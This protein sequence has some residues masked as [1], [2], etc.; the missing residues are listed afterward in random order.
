[1]TQ[2]PLTAKDIERI[3]ILA[4]DTISLNTRVI[5]KEFDADCEFGDLLVD[6]GPT[7]E[8]LVIEKDKN[9][10]LLEYVEKYLQPREEKIIKMR[11][12]LDD[13]VFKTL[14]EVAQTFGVTRERIRQLENKAI[15]KLRY[16]FKKNG[17]EGD[18][19]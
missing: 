9:K 12:G 15:N 2:K 16:H 8:E 7:V 3:L 18:A 19:L 17:I 10:I 1:M 5:N 14:E 4:Q 11:Y 13:G 6:T